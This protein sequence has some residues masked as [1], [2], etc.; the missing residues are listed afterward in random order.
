MNT[1][2]TTKRSQQRIWVTDQN[3]RDLVAEFN[4]TGSHVRNCLK[5]YTDSE[6]AK[7]VRVRA[8]E[9]ME[10]VMKRNEELMSEYDQD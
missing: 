3:T 8:I 7:K 9:L 1:E 6:L 5:F 10:Q 4:I 2:T